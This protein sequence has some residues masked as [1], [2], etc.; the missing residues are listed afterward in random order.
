MA[1]T[2]L[3]TDEILVNMGPQHPSTHGV[4]RLVLRTDGEL[5]RATHPHIGY[6]H[7]CAEKIGEK[8]TVRQYIPF[9][10]RMDYLAPLAANVGFALAIEKLLGIEVPERCSA[11]R[12]I[13]CELARIG[14][15]L[16]WLGTHALDLGAA[17]A[18]LECP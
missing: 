18:K 5:V 7:R 8:V 2:L 16:L 15:H 10:D 11:I 13:C 4:L 14:S 3:K 6:L 1:Q 17:T 9:T 12:V